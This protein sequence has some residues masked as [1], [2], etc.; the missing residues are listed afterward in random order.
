MAALNA[1]VRNAALT[2][3]RSILPGNTHAPMLTKGPRLV[4]PQAPR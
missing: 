3:K 1:P 2:I 4:V